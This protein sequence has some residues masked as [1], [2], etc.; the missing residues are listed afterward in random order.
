[1]MPVIGPLY[2]KERLEEIEKKAAENER[3]AQEVW[4]KLRE[5][6]GPIKRRWLPFPPTK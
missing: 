2:S 6:Q 3:R 5:I 4:A 1:M